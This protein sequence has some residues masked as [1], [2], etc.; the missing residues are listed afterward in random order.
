MWCGCLTATAVKAP[1]R[2]DL[3]RRPPGRSRSRASPAGGAERFV[4][5]ADRPAA[6]HVGRLMLA[7]APPG[8]SGLDA[9]TR[10]KPLD[11][12]PAALRE[13][14]ESQ[15]RQAAGRRVGD[16]PGADTPP[17]ACSPIDQA[18]ARDVRTTAAHERLAAAPH[19]PSPVE[20]PALN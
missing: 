10:V 2:P 8:L 11:E 12:R 1:A 19:N 9:S 15:I 18:D 13:W 16:G 6:S 17:T 4:Q 3:R 20:P 14:L 5:R 7:T